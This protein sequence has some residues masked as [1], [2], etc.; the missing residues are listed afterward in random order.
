MLIKIILFKSK[1]FVHPFYLST[2]L[3]SSLTNI[4]THESFCNPF[5]LQVYNGIII[6]FVDFYLAWDEQISFRG[7][8]RPTFVV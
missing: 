1:Q 3:A 2:K 7:V 5:V 4:S 6:L 8:G